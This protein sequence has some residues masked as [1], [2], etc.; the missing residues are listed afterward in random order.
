MNMESKCGWRFDPNPDAETSKHEDLGKKRNT[1][2]IKLHV[3]QHKAS[4]NC[5]TGLCS[6]LN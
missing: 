4:E 6:R 3:D 5:P 2:N 1:S